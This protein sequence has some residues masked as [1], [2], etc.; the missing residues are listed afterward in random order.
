M[1]L[2]TL[3]ALAA[4]VFATAASAAP[5]LRGEVTVTNAIVTVGDMFTDAGDLAGTPM[6]RSPAPGTTGTVTLDAVRQA[7]GL[8]GLTDYTADGILRVRVVRAATVIDEPVLTALITGDLVARGIVR[9]G[10]V[11]DATFDQSELPLNAEAVPDPVQLVSLRYTPANG[12]FAV[13]RMIAGTDAPVDRSGR[14][15]LMVEAPHLVANRPAGAILVP[16]DIERRL[17]PL[18]N[19]ESSGAA[20][21]DQLI[22]K[23]LTRQSRGGL[24]LRPTDVTEPRVVE[25]NAM[26]TVIL[27]QGPMM[28]TV[29]GQALNGASVGQPVQVLNATS[30]KILHGVALPSGV[31]EITTILAVAGL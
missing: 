19:A 4:I 26:V 3:I 27:R 6:F 5:A 23:Q 8:A 15:E 25:R 22:G 2:A 9:E 13:R 30:R 11:V 24:M 14:I 20:A 21:L 29:K 16:E 28:L 18:R 17:V 12:A 7:A 10:I 31:V 1:K